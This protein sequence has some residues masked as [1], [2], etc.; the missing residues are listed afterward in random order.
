[1]IGP[2]LAPAA[3]FSTW[4]AWHVGIDL[5][6]LA[7]AGGLY[8]VPAFA[9]VQAW[10]PADQRA[11]VVA[12]VNVLNAACIVAGL[13]ATIALQRLGA[14]FSTIFLILGIASLCASAWILS[15]L[16]TNPLRDLG[17]LVFRL[18]YR[19]EVHGQE[20]LEAAGP[21]AIIALNHVSLLDAP[22][23]FS[24]LDQDPVFAVDTGWANK[25]WMKPLVRH[26]NALP[27]DPTRPLATRQLIQAVKDGATL[28]IFPEGRLTR[29]GSLMK[30]YDG[31]GLIADKTG[32]PIVPVRIEGA[33]KTRFSYLTDRQVNRPWFKRI[34]VTILPPRRLEVAPELKGRARRQA[35]GA[36]L[37]SIMSEMIFETTN[38]DRTVFQAVVD[39][40][41]EHGPKHEAFQDPVSGTMTYKRALIGA[42]VLGSKLMPL[43]GEGRA[44]GL[45][46]PNSIGAVVSL[47]ALMSAGK[48]RGHGQ[49]LRGRRQHQVGRH[50][51][52]V[53]HDRHVA[54]LHREGQARQAR[55]R[56]LPDL[57]D[58]L[59]RGRAR[60]R[61]HARTSSR[62]RWP[63]ASRWWR[64]GPT[65]PP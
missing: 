3:F 34:K 22:I 41:V 29:T 42:R 11:R 27:L 5:V 1:M 10:A 37:Y 44:I 46:L 24:V 60:R 7:V 4:R 53:R 6:L 52:A 40:A 13:V 9:A 49:L 20:N 45:M 35:A 57:Q 8:I 58:R 50:R 61:R 18:L 59:P 63:G 33:E 39:A 28:V 54:G 38:T 31:P 47:F 23:A 14:S 48:R 62:R 16:P 25:W 32:V 17:I 19:L 51:R 30:V 36:A 56:A 21:N 55:G 12:A 65:I 2:L 64:A 26:M 43:A 15:V